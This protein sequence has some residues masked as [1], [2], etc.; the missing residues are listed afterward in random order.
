MVNFRPGKKYCVRCGMTPEEVK[1]TG[2]KCSGWGQYFDKHK[3]VEERNE[4]KNI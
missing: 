4:S 1:K 2:A 3:Y